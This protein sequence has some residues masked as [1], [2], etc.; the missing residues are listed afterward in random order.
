M[1]RFTLTLE[2]PDLKP[3]QWRALRD[4]AENFLR[5]DS[6]GKS[7][8]DDQTDGWDMGYW[9]FRLMLGGRSVMEILGQESPV[10]ATFDFEDSVK[11]Q[12]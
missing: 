11:A 10:K 4:K 1:Q 6:E 2:F 3:Y 5:E 8:L 9:L 7:G 12:E